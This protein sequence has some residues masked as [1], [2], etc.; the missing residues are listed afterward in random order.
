MLNKTLFAFIVCSLALH[1]CVFNSFMVVEHEKFH[2][3]VKDGLDVSDSHIHEDDLAS[4]DGMTFP[5]LVHPAALERELH[6]P[7]RAWALGPLLPPPRNI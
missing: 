7:N 1:I 5:V 3:Q 4:E 2:P 6:I